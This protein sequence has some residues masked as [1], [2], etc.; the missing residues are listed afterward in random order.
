MLKDLWESYYLEENYNCAESLL[1]AANDYYALGLRENEM[2]LV[3]GYGRGVQTEGVCGAYLSAVGVLSMRYIDEKAHESG[4]IRPVVNLF[5][6]RLK[7]RLGTLQCS[8]LMPRNTR[9]GMRCGLTVETVCEVLEETI[10]EFDGGMGAAGL[11]DGQ[12]KA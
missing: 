11:K 6:L 3:G 8:E 9:P 1:R 5:T 2:K 7:E 10:E 4:Y 12:G